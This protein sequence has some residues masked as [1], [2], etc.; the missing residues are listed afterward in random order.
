MGPLNAAPAT[1]PEARLIDIAHGGLALARSRP[2][3]LIHV[4][5]Q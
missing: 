1:R 5:S 2:T 3:A 4:D